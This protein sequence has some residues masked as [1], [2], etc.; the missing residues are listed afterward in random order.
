MRGWSFSGWT[1]PSTLQKRLVK[2][3]L[4]R[5]IGQFL[6]EELDLDNL[7]VQLGTGF[8]QL[9]ELQLNTEVLNDLVSELPIT[10]THGKIGG[11]TA[12]VPWKDIWSG[13]CVLE[14][15]N[16]E[17]TVIPNPVVPTVCK[18]R[19][20]DSHILSSSI[21]FA[22]DFLRHEV[23]DTDE[24]EELR[25]S[26]ME[27]VHIMQSSFYKN[28][29]GPEEEKPTLGMEPGTEGLQV[30]A[31]VIDNIIS[32]VKVTFHD[33]K[34]RIHHQSKKDFL[35]PTSTTTENYK[36]YYV[37]ITVPSI[38][39][40][41]EN[42]EEE[43]ASEENKEQSFAQWPV[44]S[45]KALTLIGL[46]ISLHE[47][48]KN[49]SSVTDDKH[50]ENF[51]YSATLLSTLSNENTIRIRTK[52][53]LFGPAIAQPIHGPNWD[54]ECFIHSIVTILSPNQMRILT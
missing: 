34:A 51:A 28:K 46:N 48:E 5:A 13:N 39:Y 19:F 43:S 27:S 30:L 7:D 45:V 20:E 33:S 41:D 36:D 10:I 16:L 54:V 23:P 53:S 2:F 40:R 44:E 49:A 15:H 8:V 52:R 3:L 11:I 42:Q 38:L 22:G 24:G 14:F 31:G 26:I 21:H 25:K 29:N 35:N 12:Q 4:K 18:S 6:L 47:L 32:N 37:D 1:L 9:K 17:I 50:L